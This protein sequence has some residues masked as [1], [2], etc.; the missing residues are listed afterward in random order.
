MEENEFVVQ[1]GSMLSFG[2][3]FVIGCSRRNFASENGSS[4]LILTRD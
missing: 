1:M 4:L 2:A 3:F